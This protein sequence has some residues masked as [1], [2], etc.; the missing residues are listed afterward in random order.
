[1]NTPDETPNQIVVRL[2]FRNEFKAAQTI[3]LGTN[4]NIEELAPGSTCEVAVVLDEAS[5]KLDLRIMED[6]FSI[7]PAGNRVRFP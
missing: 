6:G 4:G 1:M 5:P 2:F 3:D 7:K